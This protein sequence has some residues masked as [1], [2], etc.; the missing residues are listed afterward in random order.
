MNGKFL[1]LLMLSL[2]IV[3]ILFAFGSYSAGNDYESNNYMVDAFL[4]LTIAENP[5]V[6][7]SSGGANLDSSFES[8]I[9]GLTQ[10]ESLGT[11]TDLGFFAI[12][13]GLKMVLAF[14]SILTP[15]PILA[16]FYSLGMPFWFN[17]ILGLPLLLL[18]ILAI[19]EFLRGGQ[20]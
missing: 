9:E 7:E 2:N 19:V 11:G 10:Q 5:D 6:L 13:D 12:L 18:Y 14:L 15:L 17:L 1:V 3:S 16:F 8:S 20:L 4:D